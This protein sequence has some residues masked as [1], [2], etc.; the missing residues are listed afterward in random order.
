MQAVTPLALAYNSQQNRVT[1]FSPN[2][3]YFGRESVH[4]LTLK[5]QPDD[6]NNHTVKSPAEH[7]LH[8]KQRTDII[9]EKLYRASQLYLKKM[10]DVY[11]DHP[12]QDDICLLYTSDAADDA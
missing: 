8:L 10:A 12:D 4:P 3:I 6:D 1:G 5:L 11:R 9:S 2:L 7:L